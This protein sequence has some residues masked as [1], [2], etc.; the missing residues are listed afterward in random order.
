M[1]GELLARVRQREDGSAYDI[2]IAIY[3]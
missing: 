3:F 1:A 2:T